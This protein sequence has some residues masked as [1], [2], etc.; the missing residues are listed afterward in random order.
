MEINTKEIAVVKGQVSKA[1]TA[2]DSIIIVDDATMLEAGETRKKIKLVGKLIKEK[3]EEITKPMNEA[4]KSVRAL[5]APLED[6]YERVESL[7]AS[8]MVEYQRKVDAER[9]RVEDEATRKLAEAQRKAAEGTITDKQAQRVEKSV[10]KKLE[11]TPEVIK[12][13]EAFHTRT[14]KKFRILDVT[15]IPREYLVPDE[16]KIRAA[17]MAGQAVSGVE[18]YE[19]KIIV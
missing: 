3:K 12:K 10:E 16:V 15:A 6:G 8:K 19:D 2:A 4:L 11:A 5:F 9:R 7:I 18:Y 17:M 14:V 1:Q 13:S